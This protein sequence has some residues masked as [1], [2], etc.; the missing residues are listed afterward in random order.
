VPKRK[1]PAGVRAKRDLR[2]KLSVL[3]CYDVELLGETMDYF[4]R[5]T[6]HVKR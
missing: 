4:D 2:E 3:D 6:E 1:S 5:Y